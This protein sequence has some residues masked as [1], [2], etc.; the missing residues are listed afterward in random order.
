MFVAE[1]GSNLMNWT[2]DVDKL[3]ASFPS[4]FGVNFDSPTA[5]ATEGEL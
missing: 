2:Q 1:S 3:A 4:A 5:W